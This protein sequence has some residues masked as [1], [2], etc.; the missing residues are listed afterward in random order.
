MTHIIKLII[1]F[2][3]LISLGGC[4]AEIGSALGIQLIEKP[5]V[6]GESIEKYRDAF[7]RSG[8]VETV[9]NGEPA[10]K[11]NL[12]YYQRVTVEA[13][14]YAYHNLDRPGMT[15]GIIYED[16]DIL[17]PCQLT[18]SYDPK[19]RLVTD[20]ELTNPAKCGE[21]RRALREI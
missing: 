10:Y 1:S 11:W 2:L 17:R 6:R 13:D 20:F 15:T 7:G 14:T 9:L 8:E 5:M 21:V 19:T 4:A 16:R 3:T 12:S 18:M